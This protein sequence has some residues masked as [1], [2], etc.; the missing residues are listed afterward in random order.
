MQSFLVQLADRKFTLLYVPV[1]FVPSVVKLTDNS[2]KLKWAAAYLVAQLPGA[3]WM[4]RDSLSF[5]REYEYKKH[6]RP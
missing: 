6:W 3:Y 5:L 4:R 2:G 1:R